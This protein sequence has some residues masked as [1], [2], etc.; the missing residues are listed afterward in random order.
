MGKNNIVKYPGYSK[1][2]ESKLIR[3]IHRIAFLPGCTKQNILD[4]LK[5]IP[6]NAKLTEITY[7]EENNDFT[8]IDFIE[9][10]I[11]K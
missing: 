5:D 4:M 7:S 8:T 11:L 6:N 2:V 3:I 10:N 1:L 9:E